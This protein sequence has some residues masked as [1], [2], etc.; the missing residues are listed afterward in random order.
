[1][2]EGFGSKRTRERER[3]RLPMSRPLLKALQRALHRQG[4]P[5]QVR[6]AGGSTKRSASMWSSFKPKTSPEHYHP[7]AV[8]PEGGSVLGRFLAHKRTGST[9][10]KPGTSSLRMPAKVAA[11]PRWKPAKKAF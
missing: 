10:K 9:A 7:P 5:L 4:P 11:T 1:M 2:W 6:G 3:S 8:K